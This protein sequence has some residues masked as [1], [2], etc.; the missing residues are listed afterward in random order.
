M[1]HITNVRSNGYPSPIQLFNNQIIIP[2][3]IHTYTQAV[4]EYIIEGYE[5]D[6]DIY[7]KDEYIILMAQQTNR[8]AQLED[9]L[10]AAK[11]LLGVDE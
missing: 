9:E 2:S 1:Q 8:I 5:Y 11:I 6:C 10:A 3:N 7:T 4:E